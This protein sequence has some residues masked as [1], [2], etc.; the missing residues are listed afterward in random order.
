MMTVNENINKI[1][2]N[3]IQEHIERIT[4]HDE[5]GFTLGTQ[6]WFNI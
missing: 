2:V 4:H 5:V 1:L 6:G 3:Q